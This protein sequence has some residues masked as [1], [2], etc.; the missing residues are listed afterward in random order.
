M[1]VK[2]LRTGRTAE[3]NA[4]FAA[5]LIEQGRAV[6][7]RASSPSAIAPVKQEPKKKAQTKAKTRAKE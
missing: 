2:I 7:L 4:S 1:K 5:R 3:Y 6:P